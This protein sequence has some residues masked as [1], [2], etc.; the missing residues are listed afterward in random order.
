MNEIQK[1]KNNKYLRINILTLPNG[2]DLIKKPLHIDTPYPTNNNFSLRFAIISVAFNCK[3]RWF[4]RRGGFLDSGTEGDDVLQNTGTYVP[5]FVCSFVR[6][7]VRT[8]QAF[9]G[10]KSALSQLKSTLSGLKST[11][12]GLKSVLSGPKSALSGPL[13]P[14]VLKN[15]LQ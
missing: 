2:D 13:R 9:S 6:S 3:I 5:P 15:A 8:P 14:C 12:S 11:F 7:L 10:R 4:H 1:R